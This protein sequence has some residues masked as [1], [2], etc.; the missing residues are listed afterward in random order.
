MQA[1][2]QYSSGALVLAVAERALVRR[3]CWEDVLKLRRADTRLV[4]L[5]LKGVE[6]VSS[7]FLEA[8]VELSSALADQTQELALLHVSPHQQRLLEMVQGGARLPVLQREDEIAGRLGR[9][10]PAAGPVAADEGVT[11]FEKR[12]LWG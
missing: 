12:V 7:L 3:P 2:A 9:P 5:D 1:N 11:P 8:C 4:V 6:F 10:A